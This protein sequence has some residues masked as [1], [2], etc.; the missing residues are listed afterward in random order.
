M[1]DYKAPCNNCP[2]RKDMAHLFQLEPTRLAEIW[3]GPSF[4]CHKTTGVCGPKRAPQQCA[5]LIAAQHAAG[6][7]NSITQVATRIINYDPS[8]IDTTL[9]FSS[10][11]EILKAHEGQ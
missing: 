7:L 8:T 1:F 4:E 2:F 9:T 5:G 10:L 3:D 11:G 6:Q